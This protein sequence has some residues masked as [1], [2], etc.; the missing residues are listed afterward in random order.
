MN[1]GT[2]LFCL[3][4]GIVF[5]IIGGALWLVIRVILLQKKVLKDYKNKEIIEVK[6]SPN[7]KIEEKL[8]ISKPEKNE[9]SNNNT[10]TSNTSNKSGLNRLFGKKGKE[11]KK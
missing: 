2:L 3:L 6:N 5:G 11:V 10:F 4:I 9:T 7:E 1:F 8:D